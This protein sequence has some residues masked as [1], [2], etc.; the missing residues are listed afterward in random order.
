MEAG[1]PNDVLVWLREKGLTPISIDEILVGAKKAQ[2]KS[3]K[4]RVRSADLAAFCWQL[5]TMLEGGIPI[6]TALDTIAEDIENL[7]LQHVLQEVSTKVKKGTTFT[8]SISDF[9]KVFNQLFCS[10]VLAGETG[11]TLPLALRRLAEYL[12]NR[13]KLAKKVKGAVAYPIFVLT[14]IILIVVFIMAFIIPRFRTIFD[15]IGGKLPAFTQGFMNVYD[16]LRYNI[17][18]I[19]GAILLITIFLVLAYTKTKKGHYVFS[20]ILLSLPLLGKVFSQAFVAMF[21]RTMATLLV[22]GVSVLEVLDILATMTNNDIIKSAVIRTRD[23]IVS[24][25]NIASG[26]A[27]AGFFPNMVIKMIQVGENSGSLPKVL[28]RTSDYY[29][30]K[31]DSTVSTAMSLLEPIMIVTV[32]SIVLVI[33]LA[34][35]LPIFS[36]SEIS[37]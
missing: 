8:E 7:Q 36:M 15:Q 4:K 16:I 24:G 22:A 1:Y 12:D 6:T 21:C 10:M 31:V 35:Y 19:I 11:G 20:K 32:G 37:K 30:R 27:V 2:R 34:L 18:L 26:M 33:V 13:D 23:H 17:L 14:F 29:E 28:D 9:P 3:H 5:T 25:S